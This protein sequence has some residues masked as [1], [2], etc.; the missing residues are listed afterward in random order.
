MKLFLDTNVVLDYLAAREPFCL[1]IRPIFRERIERNF[2]LYVASMT[3]TTM[4]YVLKKHIPHAALMN[5]FM[6][7]RQAVEVVPTDGRIVDEAISSSF[8]DFEDAVQYY[9]AMSIGADVIIS[10]NANDFTEHSAIPVLSAGE[11]RDK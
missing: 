10:R 6:Q 2:E 5:E 7:L 3:F 9:T 4:E 1:D 8:S 11:F